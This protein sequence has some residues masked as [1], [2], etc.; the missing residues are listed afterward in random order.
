MSNSCSYKSNYYLETCHSAWNELRILS[1]YDVKHDSP[2]TESVLMQDSILFAP[3]GLM[4]HI[5]NWFEDNGGQQICWLKYPIRQYGQKSSIAQLIADQ[6]ASRGALA[7]TVFC[8]GKTVNSRTLLPSLVFQLG[9]SMP[10]LKPT[11]RLIIE[12]ER[13][14]M[15]TTDDHNF[16]RKL[17]IEPFLTGDFHPISPMVIVIDCI[18]WTDGDFLLDTLVWLENAFRGHTIPLQIFV[19]SEPELYTHA[20]L[21]FP[22]FM[23]N[24]LTL[25]LPRF[26]SWQSP[27]SPSQSIFA[28]HGQKIYQ[29]WDVFRW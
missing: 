28:N 14:V 29:V 24:A 23:D 10:M 15:L 20:N 4:S 12:D 13:E 6:C 8:S 16:A 5:S 9:Q 1:A 17:I 22:S 18:G 26:E 27:L 11:M 7:A 21:Q 19:A 2:S 25:H 3:D